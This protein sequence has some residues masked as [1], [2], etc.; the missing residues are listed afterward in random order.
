M[1]T[2]R[3]RH[4]AVL[5]SKAAVPPIEDQAGLLPSPGRATITVNPVPVSIAVL[6][7]IA[8]LDARSI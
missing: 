1:R 4:G 3:E 2:W 7:Q 8:D 5:V 6:E